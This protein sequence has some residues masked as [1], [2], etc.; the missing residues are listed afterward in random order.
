MLGLKSYC[1]VTIRKQLV[2][3]T[4]SMFMISIKFPKSLLVTVKVTKW[5]CMY[6]TYIRKNC[7]LRI[8]LSVLLEISQCYTHTKK[9]RDEDNI[10]IFL[11]CEIFKSLY[12]V[13]SPDESGLAPQ[14][15]VEL[16]LR[17]PGRALTNTTP[18]V[19]Q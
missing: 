18:E 13:R 11:N 16:E 10:I 19:P 2:N 5:A 6:Q 14:L 1:E 9:K 12:K 4:V 3:C 17:M 15:V 7:R 8:E